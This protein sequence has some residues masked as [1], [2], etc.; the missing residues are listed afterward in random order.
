MNIWI[1]R[2]SKHFRDVVNFYDGGS[3]ATYY[4]TI[5]IQFVKFHWPV[6][7]YVTGVG[8]WGLHSDDA[9]SAEHFSSIDGTTPWYISHTVQSDLIDYPIYNRTNG[10]L[11]EGTHPFW[12]NDGYMVQN[13]DPIGSYVNYLCST[14]EYMLSP[15]HPPPPPPSPLPSPPSPLPSPP[16]PPSTE[17]A[18]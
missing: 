8:Q 14:N 18:D 6:G 10:T 1:P 7:Y 16:S 17:L 11:V 3:Y 13:V 4:R 15:P 5:G 2:T 9:V 12:T